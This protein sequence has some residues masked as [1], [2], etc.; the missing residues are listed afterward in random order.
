[1]II[2]NRDKFLSKRIRFSFAGYGYSQLKRL[3]LH[4]NYLLNP[5]KSYPTRKELGLPNQTLIPADQ[6]MAAE[7]DIQKELD[8]LNFDFLEEVSEP[9]KIGIRS[10]MSEM[11]ATLKITS[12]DQ[13]LSA[14]RTIGLSDNF[15]EIMHKER[16]YK[17]LKS[18]YDKYEEWKKNRNPIRAAM[19]AKFG[20]DGKNA[21]YLIR[22]LRICVEV[23]S[24]RKVIVKRPDREELLSIKNGAWSYQKL[25]EEAEKLDKQAEEL[26]KTSLLPKTPN[27]QE[28]DSLCVDVVEKHLERSK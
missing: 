24:T 25:I 18:Q 6:L 17:N 9:V 28:L 13:W 4:R 20:Y 12:D 16:N 26:Y 11:L 14:A 8:K 19:E 27:F 22:L 1:M 3:E 21:L 7:A 2:D 5:P 10:K 15:I 23:L